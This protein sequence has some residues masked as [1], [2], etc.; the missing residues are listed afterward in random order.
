VA[1]VAEA[2]VAAGDARL[3]YDSLEAFKHTT[4]HLHWVR[5]VNLPIACLF[6]CKG[7]LEDMRRDTAA[8]AES[9]RTG[10]L[11]SCWHS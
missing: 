10:E 1:S 9:Q 4:G 3:E 2:V 5:A 6:G 11:A 8:P 7:R